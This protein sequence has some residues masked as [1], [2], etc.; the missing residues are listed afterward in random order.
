MNSLDAKVCPTREALFK[1]FQ[2]LVRRY[3]D[4]VMLLNEKVGRMEFKSLFEQSRV[5]RD[6]CDKA[7]IE[8]EKHC[9]EHGC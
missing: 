6:S 4:Q 2:E 5:T 3:S 1:G 8:F 9:R 7:R